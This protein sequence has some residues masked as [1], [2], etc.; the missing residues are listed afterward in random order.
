MSKS[1][2][3]DEVLNGKMAELLD[4][5]LYRKLRGETGYTDY[6]RMEMSDVATYISWAE[7]HGIELKFPVSEK[8]LK[9]CLASADQ[10]LYEWFVASDEFWRLGSNEMLKLINELIEITAFGASPAE[11]TFE[12]V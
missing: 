11:E 6:D 2:E 5:N 4:T 8:D 10:F 7:Y 3:W 9:W 1:K 12:I